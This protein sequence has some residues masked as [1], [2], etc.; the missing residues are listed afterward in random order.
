MQLAKEETKCSCTTGNCLTLD[1]PSFKRGKYCDSSCTCQGCKNRAE[2]ESERLAVI[3]KILVQNPLAFTGQ[4]TLNQEEFDSIFNFAMLNASVDSEP[5]HS[6]PRETKLSK[7]LT[8]DVINQAIKTVMCA[9]NDDI[10]N[11]TEENFEEHAEN[12]VSK[13]FANVL[14]TIVNHLKPVQPE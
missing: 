8:T 3:E 1:C 9:A 6:E 2:F 13:E 4:D 7:L 14:Q 11:S 12:S 5:F 10:Q